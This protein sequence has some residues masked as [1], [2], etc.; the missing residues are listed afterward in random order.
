MNT[1]LSKYIIKSILVGVFLVM[2]V[3]LSITMLYEFISQLGNLQGNFG[4]T[5]AFVFSLLRLP[6]LTFEM[7]PISILIG[8]ILVLISGVIGIGGGIFLS[9]ILFLLKADQP[10]NIV[11][12]ASL[13]IFVNSMSGVFGQLT[14][15]CLE[16]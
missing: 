2:A 6:Q 14:K 13:F 11:T 16:C 8:S 1:I 7:L 15:Q 9:P 5:E 3:L 10:K 12:T 4:V